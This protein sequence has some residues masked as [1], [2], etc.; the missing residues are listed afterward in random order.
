MET[1]GIQNVRISAYYP[2]AN[3]M[4]ERGHQPVVDALSKLESNTLRPWP[5]R[6]HGVL[7]AD[8]TTVRA[9]T[10]MTPAAVMYGQDHTLP[11]ELLFPTWRVTA[12]DGIQTTAQLLAAR[13]AQ[14]DRRDEDVAE[15]MLRL[16]RHREWNK[17]YF[18]AVRNIRPEELRV[19][20]LVLVFNSRR[21][22]DMSS[23]RKLAPRWRGPF[24]V[25]E[26]REGLGSYR[27]EELDSTRY[28][29]S[30]PSRLLKRFHRRSGHSDIAADIPDREETQNVTPR[31]VRRALQGVV[32]PRP[33]IDPAEFQYF[34]DD[35]DIDGNLDGE[36]H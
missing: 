29:R 25:A 17:E 27:L 35:D 12:W 11:V 6:L 33:E 24:R 34:S 32:I 5:R 16:R 10:G 2:Q 30:Y 26:T 18:N 3:G 19:G 15:A 4:V 21:D 8:R 14:L 36:Y 13:A 23:A 22:T 1:Y 9:A 7:W 20:D 31:V 28:K